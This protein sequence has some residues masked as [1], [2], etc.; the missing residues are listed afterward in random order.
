VKKK[1]KLP[2]AQGEKAKKKIRRIRRIYG[3]IFLVT[4]TLMLVLGAF[5]YYLMQVH[6][7]AILKVYAEQQD[8]YVQLVLDQINLQP[9][10]TE[11][12][13]ITDIIATLDSGNTHF[14]T[15]SRNDELLFVKNVT[16]TSKYQGSS[17]EDFNLDEA[18]EAFFAALTLNRVQHT[19]LLL[20][21]ERYVASGTLFSYND[22][23]YHLCLLTDE[24][25]ILDNND[26]LSVK[27]EMYIY[28]LVILVTLLVVTMTAEIL[29][30]RKEINI[31]KSRDRIEVLNRYV[32]ELEAELQEKESY[33]SR[34]NVYGMQMIDSFML[35]LDMNSVRRVVFA[36]L[37]FPNE[38]VKIK[39]LSDA[40]TLLD[41]NVLRFQEDSGDILLLMVHFNTEQA[42]HSLKRAGITE[43]M[44][45]LL[46]SV[47]T[48]DG[49]IQMVYK[50]RIREE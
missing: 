2:P 14:W 4:L 6:E 33:N 32:G 39:F 40:E 31:H 5:G 27:I 28:I 21:G 19:I 23:T 7:E 3:M 24:T 34:Y 15:L 47:G 36:R 50:N 1:D 17:T 20:N 11:E 29:T 44:I 12:S 25:V 35:Q 45:I 42:K 46:D 13:I 22:K 43:D 48:M 41:Q 37:H 26:F 9:D 49:S 10:R 38:M 16:E 18:G 8:N 30:Q